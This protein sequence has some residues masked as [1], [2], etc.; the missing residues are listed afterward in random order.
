MYAVDSALSRHH[1]VVRFSHIDQ[2]RMWVEQVIDASDDWFARDYWM[3][4][5]IE[6]Y[7]SKARYDVRSKTSCIAEAFWDLR[8]ATGYLWFSPSAYHGVAVAH[9][10]SHVLTNA[11]YPAPDPGNGHNARFA[12]T[13]LETTYRV[14]GQ[15]AYVRA[16]AQFNRHGVDYG[17]THDDTRHDAM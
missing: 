15:E 4:E 10:L 14:L 7:S 12:R 3:I 16:Y 17:S 6:V 9:E 2:V 5:H 11:R 1:D 8:N 13:Y